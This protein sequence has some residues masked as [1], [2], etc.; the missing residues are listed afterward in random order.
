M[1]ADGQWNGAA[2]QKTIHGA[3]GDIV[4]ESAYAGERVAKQEA[5]VDSGQMRAATHATITGPASAVLQNDVEHS[6]YNE[7]G[8]TGD[9]GKPFMRPGR[10]AGKAHYQKRAKQV[11]G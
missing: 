2:I 8:R 1:A 4:H 9:P 7:F 5:R 10:D 11:F 6:I 3:I